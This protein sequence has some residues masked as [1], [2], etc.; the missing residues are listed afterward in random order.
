MQK[1]EIS[2]SVEYFAYCSSIALF[3]IAST[4]SKAPRQPLAVY[5]RCVC[6]A[7]PSGLAASLFP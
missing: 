4:I 6:A 7:M 3:L 5:G 1:A 2:P